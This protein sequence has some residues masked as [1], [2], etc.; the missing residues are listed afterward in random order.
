M[1]TY[2]L[3]LGLAFWVLPAG[4]AAGPLVPYASLSP[5]MNV[6]RVRALLTEA[7]M[8]VE[9]EIAQEVEGTV[10]GLDLLARSSD[11]RA[12]LRFYRDRLYL[13]R[14]IFPGAIGQPAAWARQVVRTISE[15]AGEPGLTGGSIQRREVFR[16]YI[17][18]WLVGF[19]CEYA[20]QRIGRTTFLTYVNLEIQTQ[21]LT[22]RDRL[23][24]EAGTDSESGPL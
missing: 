14:V 18:D 3:I 20:N 11:E 10:I 17:G 24:E 15:R 21:F 12:L 13:V 6:T 16:W 5:G 4:L 23:R 1:R 2:R 22:E 19:H 7:G 9:R 8:T